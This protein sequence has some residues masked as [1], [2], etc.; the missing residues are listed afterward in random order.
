M[1][2]RFISQYALSCI[3][4]SMQISIII[5]TGLIYLSSTKYFDYSEL[6]LSKQFHLLLQRVLALPL[7]RCI[8]KQSLLPIQ[9]FLVLPMKLNLLA[10]LSIINRFPLTGWFTTIHWS[11]A[12]WQ[13]NIFKYI[14]TIFRKIQKSVHIYIPIQNTETT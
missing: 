13:G 1:P 2:C 7:Y 8:S 4:S 10:S 14:Q 6:S 9:L 11:K 12:I 3:V 5:H